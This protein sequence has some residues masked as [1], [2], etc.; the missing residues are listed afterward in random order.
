MQFTA[1]VQVT[2]VSRAPRAALRTL[3]E[4]ARRLRRMPGFHGLQAF[5]AMDSSDALLLLVDWESEETLR[6]ALAREEARGLPERAAR[7]GMR[8]QPVR[9]LAGTFDRRLGCQPS[10]VT[11]LRFSRGEPSPV[12]A[13]R[14]NDFALQSLAAPGSLRLHGARSEDGAASVCRID[15]DMEDGLWHFLQSPLRGQWSA[16]AEAGLEEE[17]WAIN[18]PRLEYGLPGDARPSRRLPRK[19]LDSLCVEYSLDEEAGTA[20]I[21]LQGRVDAHNS[22][23]CERLCELLLGNGCRRLEV[24]VS[25]LTRI[26]PDALAML[27]RTARGLKERG[28]QFV[29]T[30]NEERVKRVTRS[31][32]LATSVR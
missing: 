11:L 22:A 30:D 18:L 17:T 25:D 4:T 1:L 26:S 29:L 32:H 15:F 19:P 3:T 23:R 12:R 10:A 14:D 13:S 21:R 16:R 24:D 2:P 6:A 31:R 8:L 7:W 27:A 5:R 9:V 28:G 20:W